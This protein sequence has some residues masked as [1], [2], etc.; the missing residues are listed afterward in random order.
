MLSVWKRAVMAIDYEG[1]KKQ[2]MTLIALALLLIVIIAF[3]PGY[4]G[5]ANKGYDART[6]QMLNAACNYANEIL[7]EDQSL[8]GIDMNALSSSKGFNPPPDYEFSI[9]DGGR[10]TL[11]ISGR[12]RK[13]KKTYFADKYCVEMEAE[14]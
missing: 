10:S 4:L 9:V 11:K 1:T 7:A 14:R 6:R 5:A 13:S 8:G 2:W 3:V 12:H